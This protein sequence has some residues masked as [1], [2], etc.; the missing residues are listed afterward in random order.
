MILY[1]TARRP[2]S[3]SRDPAGTRPRPATLRAPLPPRAQPGERGALPPGVADRPAAH[4]RCP[5]RRGGGGD[6]A[7]PL[8][9]ALARG[10]L[11]V[12]GRSPA[13]RA[14]LGRAASAPRPLGP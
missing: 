6:V 13:T 2:D 8:A 3:P 11:G 12:P 4:A 14:G 1:A 9:T 7:R 10:A 5:Q